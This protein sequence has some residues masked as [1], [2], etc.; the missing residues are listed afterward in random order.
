MMD[1]MSMMTN[2]S[3]PA[4]CIE[5]YIETSISFTILSDEMFE[6]SVK[7]W[8]LP[9]DFSKEDAV[10]MNLYFSSLQTEVSLARKVGINHPIL[11]SIGH[12]N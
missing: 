1:M 3:C 5:E 8:N 6:R 9:N 12:S 10:W 4:A 11:N 7:A 2:I